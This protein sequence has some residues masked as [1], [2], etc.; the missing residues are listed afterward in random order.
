MHIKNYL[1]ILQTH[2]LMNLGATMKKTFLLFTL[3]LTFTLTVNAQQTNSTLTDVGELLFTETFNDYTLA[4]LAGQ[5]TWIKGGSGPE[6]TVSEAAVL[7]YPGYDFGGG[8]VISFPVGTSTT[9]RV[10]SDFTNTS[11]SMTNPG[12]VVYFSLLLN[13]TSTNTDGTGYFFSLGSAPGTTQYFAKMFAKT[14]SEGKYFLGIS[15][16][17]NTANFTTQE[18]NLNQTYFVVVRYNVN[19]TALSQSGNTCYMWV[20]LTDGNEPDTLTADAKVWAGQP[21]YDAPSISAIMWHSRKAANPLGYLDGIRVAASATSSTAAWIALAPG[22]VPVELTSFSAAIVKDAVQLNWTTATETNNQGFEI[23]RRSE[24]KSWSKIAV[25]Q[26]KGTTTQNS[27]YSY[28]DKSVTS[29]KYSYRL[30]Q[31]DFDGTYSYSQETEV[32]LSAP[33]IFE[34]NQNYPNP[35]NPS[36]TISFSLPQASNVTLKVYNM[37]GQEVRSLLNEFKE[38]GKHN[39]VFNADKLNSGLYLYKIEAGNFTQ[40]RKMTLLK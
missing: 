10:Y 13:L 1:F 25:V 20:D 16:S 4:N 34:L 8:K 28:T 14:S 15:K 9:S 40:V 3:L 29:G 6:V 27:S 24:G 36:T 7:E 11:Y 33:V 17:S 31:V 38:A 32:N 30:K 21:D 35:F 12:T 37:L 2:I 5:N 22:I 26:G 18:L 39:V 23:E 19:N